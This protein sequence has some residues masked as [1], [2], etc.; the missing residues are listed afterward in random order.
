[1]TFLKTLLPITALIFS[2]SYLS[3]QSGTYQFDDG[4][5]IDVQVVTS[6]PDKGRNAAIFVGAIGPEVLNV[7]GGSYYFP[8]KGYVQAMAGP[9][10]GIVD[11]NVIL[12]S[13]TK[14]INMKQSVRMD[15][16][17]LGRQVKYVVKIPSEKRVSLGLHTGASYYNYMETPF[18]AIGLIG[19]LSLLKARHA[20]W[21]IEGDYKEGRGTAVSRINA[22]AIF[23]VNHTPTGEEGEVSIKE[24]TRSL[25]FRVYF[26]GKA[27]LWSRGGKVALHYMLGY[28]QGA[29][30]SGS[31]LLGGLGLGYSFR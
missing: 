5:E 12:A 24:D 19:G 15:R 7:I 4:T 26:D 23:Y 22:D 31:P 14:P 17:N 13:K 27:T 30:R 29:D 18:S 3:A 28:G 11:G 20:H 10:G 1:M 25:G 21:L 2:S 9:W 8:S 6:N 16:D